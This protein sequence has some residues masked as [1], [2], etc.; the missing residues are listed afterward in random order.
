MQWLDSKKVKAITTNLL[1]P[2]PEVTQSYFFYV[3]VV[4]TSHRAIS[5]SKGM[6]RIPS[7]D[8]KYSIHGQGGEELRQ[9]C[10]KSVYYTYNSFRYH[11]FMNEDK[12]VS[13]RK[14]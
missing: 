2:S 4:K 7:P 14:K 6:E 12:T 3:L 8:E 13:E 5:D 9:L 11:E 10:R 1:R